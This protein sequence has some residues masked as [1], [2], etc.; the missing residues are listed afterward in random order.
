MAFTASL[1]QPQQ[2]FTADEMVT[3]LIDS[4]W[5]DRHN[6]AIERNLKVRLPL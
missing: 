1:E 5:D 6:R 3:I 2:R 4:E